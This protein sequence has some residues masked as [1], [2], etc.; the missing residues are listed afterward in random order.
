LP[1]TADPG[2]PTAA[3][4][5]FL[6][7][8]TLL[9]LLLTGCVMAGNGLVVPML[10]IYGQQFSAS[11]ALV[12]MIIT[13]F[14]IGRMAISLPTGLL[15]RRV[16]S[17]A[18]LVGGNGLLMLG[19]AGAALATDLP[20]LL[21]ARLV[22]G[23]GSGIYLTA[24]GIVIAETSRPETRGR[25]MA[26]YQGAIYTGAGIGPAIGGFLA[27]GFGIT[28]PFWA[29]ALLSLF[30]MM[31]GLWFPSPTAHSR[32]AEQRPPLMS[33]LRNLPLMAVFLLSF[34]TGF[35]RTAAHWQMVPLLGSTRLQMGFDDIGLVLTVNAFMNVGVLPFTGWLIDRF[36]ARRVTPLAA[37]SFAASL[38]VIAFDG[39][40]AGFWI[41]MILL[42]ITGGFVS[43]TI[44]ASLVDAAPRALLGPAVGTQ[45]SIGD[46]GFLLGPV[47]IGTL[48]DATGVGPATGLMAIA[49]V[50]TGAA[51]LCWY[52]ARR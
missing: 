31:V 37:L 52:A 10:T 50:V 45:R 19:A 43:P 26:L 48:L 47:L 22:Q 23:I 3:K 1:D 41:G 25:F 49:V 24:A 6:T 28:A 29:Y 20:L 9:L 42:G 38:L 35:T 44:G 8:P 40:L 15:A 33:L 16:G 36:G 34:A 17:R 11:A 5:R 39:G 30:A 13:I 7:L 18:L 2:A 46:L 12:G 51:A 4:P 14:G 27:Q 32:G 21:L